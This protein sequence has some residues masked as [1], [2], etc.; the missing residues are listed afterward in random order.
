MCTARYQA[1]NVETIQ[2]KVTCIKVLEAKITRVKKKKKDAIDLEVHS[3]RVRCDVRITLAHEEDYG[4]CRNGDK[5]I[6]VSV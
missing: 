5:V 6:T 4:S 1:D 3:K 2:I